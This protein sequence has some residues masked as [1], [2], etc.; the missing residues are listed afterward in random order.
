MVFIGKSSP[1]DRKIQVG[2]RKRSGV[3]A[4]FGLVKYHNLPRMMISSKSSPN[5]LIN[6]RPQVEVVVVSLCDVAVCWQWQ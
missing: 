5:S 3:A 2:V 1:N 6:A 4:R